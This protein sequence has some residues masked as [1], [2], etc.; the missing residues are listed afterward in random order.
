MDTE[1]NVVHLKRLG[2]V[3]KTNTNFHY[4]KIAGLQRERLPQDNLEVQQFPSSTQNSGAHKSVS[5]KYPTRISTHY[6]VTPPLENFPKE[7]LSLSLKL[8]L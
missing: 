8:F 3:H 6:F 5:R 1:F 7:K 2:Y 4:I